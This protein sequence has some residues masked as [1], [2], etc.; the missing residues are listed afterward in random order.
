MFEKQTFCDSAI[1]L[2]FLQDHDQLKNWNCHSLEKV[3]FT[4][5]FQNELVFQPLNS[6]VSW[7][8]KWQ[9]VVRKDRQGRTSIRFCPTSHCPFKLKDDFLFSP[10]T[11]ILPDKSTSKSNPFRTINSFVQG[12]KQWSSTW[13]TDARKE[14]EIN[15]RL[16]FFL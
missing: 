14:I 9:R 8:R 12:L 11:L 2:F 5:I 16:Y 3:F 10:A 13:G 15:I 1:L 7:K 6:H 4:E